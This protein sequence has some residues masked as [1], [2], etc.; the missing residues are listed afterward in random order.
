MCPPP[1]ESGGTPPEVADADS[2][3]NAEYDA[4]DRYWIVRKAVEDALLNV[5]WTLALVGFGLALVAAGAFAVLGGDGSPISVLVGVA[6]LGLG[7]GDLA[8]S[9]DVPLPFV[10]AD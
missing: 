9:L 6:L 10:S 8:A 2:R 5:F 3:D 7:A 4:T 1:D